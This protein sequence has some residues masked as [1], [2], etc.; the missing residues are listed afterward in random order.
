MASTLERF[1]AVLDHPLRRLRLP[2][3]TSALLGLVL[4]LVDPSVDE[5]Q[6]PMPPAVR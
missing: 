6:L 5:G 3:L 1:E 2:L 4:F